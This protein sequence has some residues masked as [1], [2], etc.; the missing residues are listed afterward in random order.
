VGAAMVVAILA[1]PSPGQSVVETPDVASLIEPLVDPTEFLPTLR[2]TLPLT[3][4]A[5]PDVSASTPQ[6]ALTAAPAPRLAAADWQKW[7]AIPAVSPK[8]REVYQK[9]LAMG[10]DPHAFSKV[11]DCQNVSSYFLAVF[12]KP[13]DVRLGKYASLQETIDHFEGSFLR[14][15]IAV[16][17]GFNVA[18]VLSP[19]WADPELCKKGENPL[20]CEFRHQ[21]PGIVFISMET[22][23][24]GKP[25]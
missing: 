13:D 14:E 22:W 18:S 24:S 9:G 25:A 2:P 15:S 5:T 16:R 1:A 17:G 12:E 20:Q 11:G 19:F 4:S 10:N 23:W 3:P 8:M 7:P 21:R 6:A